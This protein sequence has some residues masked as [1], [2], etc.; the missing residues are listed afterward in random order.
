MGVVT[1]VQYR[2]QNVI[3]NLCAWIQEVTKKKT[4]IIE[5]LNLIFCFPSS[6]T[7]ELDFVHITIENPSF[8][9][10]TELE[11]I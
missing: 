2:T 11:N 8:P 5:L 9:L 10:K 4:L 3:T 1:K 6:K 7:S